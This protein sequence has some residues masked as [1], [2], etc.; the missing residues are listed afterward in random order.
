MKFLITN[1]QIK[2]YS[3]SEINALSIAEALTS[4]GHQ[5]EV[6]T[7]LVD[8]PM[9]EIFA[10]KGIPVI[11]LLDG[12]VDNFDHD[13][14]WGH[15]FPTM[16]QVVLKKNWQPAR[17]L[18]SSL[19]TIM[20]IEAPPAFHED[21]PLFLSHNPVN[22]EVLIRNGVSASKIHYFPNYADS[23]FFRSEPTISGDLRKILIVSNHPPVELLEFTERARKLSL[24]VDLVGWA[25]EPKLVDVELLTKYDLII[26]IGKTVV[27]CFAAQVPVYC[28][29][30]FGGQGY[31][32]ED[33]Y[34]KSLRHN[35]SGKGFDRFLSGQELVK[36]IQ[37]GY[38]DAVN[39]SG[40]LK[41]RCE[42]ELNLEKN[43]R[44]LCKRIE[45][46]PLAIPNEIKQ[47]YTLLERHHDA[48]PFWAQFFTDKDL[49]ARKLLAMQREDEENSLSTD[50]L[51]VFSRLTD[52]VS[53]MQGQ[54]ELLQSEI[55]ETNKVILAMKNSTSW[56]ISRPVRLIK[57][58]LLKLKKK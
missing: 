34:E 48:Q 10:Q 16:T 22:T 14:I 33:N 53:E 19:S 35:F 31:I 39:R 44:V 32:T 4:F 55:L 42:E 27:Y 6:G 5:V 49:I 25:G 13:V 21:I 8:S 43:L 47:K 40:W 36:D 38:D 37:S 50:K 3:G 18:F 23:S 28:Y 9:K 57:D 46:L 30:H 54:V 56:K 29:D 26:T 2:N 41:L 15:H 20:P 7:F 45:Q 11:K 52:R 1:I 12:S 24:E 58:L 51:A 17:L